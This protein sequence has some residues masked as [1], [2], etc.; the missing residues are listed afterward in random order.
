[1]SDISVGFDMGMGALKLYGARGGMQLVSQVATNGREHLAD[2]ILGLKNRKRP[3]LVESEA[4]SFY[5]GDYA[6]ENGRP[7][8]NMDFERLIGSPE[9]K[10]LLY[11][12]LARYQVEHGQFRGPINLMAGLPLQMMTGANAKDYQKSIRNWLKDTHSF[13]VDGEAFRVEVE[14][15]KQTSQPVGALMDYVRDSHG[16]IIPE[17]GGVLLEEVG[18]VSVGFNTVELLVVK[19]Q[20]AFD[21]FTRGNTLGVRRLLEL[22]NRDGMYSRS[23]L[24]ARLRAGKMKTEL[25]SAL[26]VWSR[27]VNGEI[28]DVW[29]KFYNRFS[30]VLIVGGGALLLGDALSAQF[31]HKAWMPDDSVMSI[32]RG[33]YKLSV[34]IRR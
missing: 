2:G 30:K 21:R 31:G 11:A 5:V 17:R 33:L 20:R 16:E 34:A 22:M 8:E 18:I 4:G 24:D 1:M 27:E 10:A 23:E 15:V 25:K 26:P 3:M 13:T 29:G 9:I 7:V 12:A 6:H 14:D 19:E 28:E 32:A